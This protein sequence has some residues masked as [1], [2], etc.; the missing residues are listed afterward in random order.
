M[1]SGPITAWKIEGEKAEIMTDFLFLGSKITVDDDCC[2]K[3]RWLLLSRKAITNLHSVLKSRDITIPT[4][5][6]IV[7]AMVF[8]A[9][10]YGCESS[11]IEKAECQRTDV[12]TVVLEKTPESSLDSKEIKPVNLKGDQPWIFTGR[13]D[14]EAEA[15]VF[16]SSDTNRWLTGKVP[17]AGKDWGQKEKRASEDEMAGR[18][19]QYNGH[20]FGQTLGDDEGQG[21]PECCSPWDHRVRHDWVTEQQQRTLW[22]HF[23]NQ[24]NYHISH[25]M[26]YLFLWEYLSS[27]VNKFQLYNTA[28]LI[29]VT[30]WPYIIHSDLNLIMKNSYSFSF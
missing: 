17:D 23:H 8:P 22:K 6:C 11:T 21:D 7:K 28:F 2:H 25:F 24:V 18:H 19:Y 27:I 20:E 1:A 26:Y 12:Q 13:T 30:M 10:T 5:V 9:V 15:P 3:I 14:A 4:K 29:I 16:R